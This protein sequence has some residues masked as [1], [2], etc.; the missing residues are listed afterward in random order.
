MEADSVV[1]HPNKGVTNLPISW[2][3][4]FFKFKLPR[5][6]PSKIPRTVAR[7][8]LT[9]LDL[10]MVKTNKKLISKITETRNGIEVQREFKYVVSQTLR[11]EM[12]VQ[13]QV[14][15]E[16]AQQLGITEVDYIRIWIVDIQP[17]ENKILIFF[18]D[19]DDEIIDRTILVGREWERCAEILTCDKF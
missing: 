19:S 2:E 7:C 18:Y 4:G 3:N 1:E 12:L 13:Y 11:K 10:E 5:G 16:I 17:K 6:A 9:N 8:S 15:V 14:A